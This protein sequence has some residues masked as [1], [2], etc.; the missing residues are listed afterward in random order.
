M[1]LIFKDLQGV[2]DQ[3]DRPGPGSLP[4]HHRATARGRAKGLLGIWESIPYIAKHL[5]PFRLSMA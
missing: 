2:T 3:C 4:T 5:P 1:L